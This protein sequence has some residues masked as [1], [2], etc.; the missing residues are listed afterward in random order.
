MSQA[1]EQAAP[2]LELERPIA[3]Y[4]CDIDGCLAAAD[5]AAYDLEALGKMAAYNARA[6]ADEAIPKLTLVTGRPQPYADAVSQMLAVDLP[7]SFENG[8]GLAT[9]RPNRAWLSSEVGSLLD[10]LQAFAKAV[11]DEPK[12]TLQLGKVA[13]LSVFPEASDYPMADLLHDVRTLLEDGGYPLHLDPS[14]GCINVLIPGI[15]KTSGFDW[16]LSE[17]DA[18]PA[19][20]A[21]IGDSVGDLGWLGRCGLSVAPVNAVPEVIAAVDLKL[22]GRDVGSALAAYEALIDANRKLLQR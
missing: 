3:I 16:L 4:A 2:A 1:A 12:L 10:E 22:P 18:D 13:S 15:D 8:A 5:H 19:A 9:R 6:G 17:I 20:V 11:E 21:G 7:Y 14:T